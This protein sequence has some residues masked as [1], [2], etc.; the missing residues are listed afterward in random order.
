MLTTGVLHDAAQGRVVDVRYA[1]EKVVLD[2]EIQTADK[3]RDDRVARGEIGRRHYLVTRPVGF[4]RV[5]VFTGLDK[6][7]FLHR[8]SQLEYDAD[9]NARGERVQQITDQVFGQRVVLQR[10]ID[11]EEDVQQLGEPKTD[12]RTQR[13][14]DVSTGCDLLVEVLTDVQEEDP[15]HV[16]QAVA[17]RPVPMLVFVD[18]SLGLSGRHPEKW[19]IQNVIIVILHIREGVVDDIVLDVPQEGACA[20]HVQR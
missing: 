17:D 9:H 18:A 14:F 15:R 10:D 3:P 19:L 5:A 7:G 6:G 2:L 16:H 1:R 20:K 12:M 8:V 4:Q 11:E 13:K